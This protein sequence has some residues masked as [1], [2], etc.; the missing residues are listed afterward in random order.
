MKY[1]ISSIALGIALGLA[2]SPGVLQDQILSRVAMVFS[3]IAI[4]T[5]KHEILDAIRED[6]K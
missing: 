5:I 3:I 2:F 1:I 6:K 4:I